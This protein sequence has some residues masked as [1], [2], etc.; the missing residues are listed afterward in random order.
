VREVQA[1][2]SRRGVFVAEDVLTICFAAT[3]EWVKTPDGLN[4]IADDVGFEVE[5]GR[6]DKKYTYH[7]GFG[8]KSEVDPKDIVYVRTAFVKGLPVPTRHIEEDLRLED[9]CEICGIISHCVKTV[10]DEENFNKKV[11]ACEHCLSFSESLSL[12]SCGDIEKC[13]SCIILECSHH[14]LRNA[15]QMA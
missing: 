9:T 8:R 11:K 15:L 12:K 6:P 14:P 1:I 7:D 13:Q 2:L 3:L 10:R 4:E 5:E